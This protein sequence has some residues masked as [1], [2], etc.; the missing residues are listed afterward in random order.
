MDMSGICLVYGS[1]WM[2][3]FVGESDYPRTVSSIRFEKNSNMT[4]TSRIPY[5]VLYTQKILT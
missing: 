3:S 1:Q 5:T 4:D 2:S